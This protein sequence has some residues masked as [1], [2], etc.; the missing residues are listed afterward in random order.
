MEATDKY[1]EDAREGDE[2]ISPTYKVTKE[3]LTGDHTPLHVSIAF[4]RVCH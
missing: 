2:A 3:N 4:D 1:W